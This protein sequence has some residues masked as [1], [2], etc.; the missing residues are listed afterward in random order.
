MLLRVRADAPLLL[1]RLTTSATTT[2]SALKRLA[3]R[4]CHPRRRARRS[5]LREER[6]VDL[7]GV[8]R[9]GV[10]IGVESYSLKNIESLL[11]V[12]PAQTDPAVSRAEGLR[13]I[14][15]ALES[16][17][18]DGQSNL[19]DL[20]VRW[21]LTT[22]KTASPPGR[23]RDWLEQR[24]AEL[25]EPGER[26]WRDRRS[27]T[28][29]PPESSTKPCSAPARWLPAFWLGFPTIR[30]SAAPE[31]T[32]PGA[33]RPEP[34]VPPPRGQGGLVGAFSAGQAS[35]T[36]SEWKILPR[37]PAWFSPKP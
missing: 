19:H 22:G 24:R 29:A 28:G 4:H 8:L 37:S 18:P 3:T 13:N 6:F 33:A 9:Q 12:S 20:A 14:E 32:S 25:L 5:L 1:P 30:R 2:S 35:M 34:R 21:R 16:S 10:R 23:V 17:W 31:Q 36:R 27:A 15:I 7:L 26:R 11:L